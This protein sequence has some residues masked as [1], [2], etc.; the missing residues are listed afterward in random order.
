MQALSCG[1]IQDLPRRVLRME[2]VAM[3]IPRNKELAKTGQKVKML[4]EDLQLFMQ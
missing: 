3:D 2:E 1:E 4:T